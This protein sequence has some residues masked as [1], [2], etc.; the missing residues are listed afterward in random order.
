MYIISKFDFCLPIRIRQKIQKELKYVRF[1]RNIS[2]KASITLLITVTVLIYSVITLSGYTQMTNDIGANLEENQQMIQTLNQETEATIENNLEQMTVQMNQSFVLFLNK[3]KQILQ[4]MEQ[5][6]KLDVLSE[7]E[8]IPQGQT[9]GTPYEI[10]P[11]ENREDVNRSL[12]PYF[13]N[14]VNGIEEIQ[15]AYVG[16]PDQ[17]MYI[18]PLGDF[19]FKEYDP[20]D[21]P[22]YQNAVQE[23]D[24]Y[25]WTDPYIDAI[26]EK[27]VMTLAK[28]VSRNDE[29][30][31]VTAMDF[32]LDTLSETVTD[33][34]IAD[35]GYAMLLDRNGVLLAHPHAEDR[36]GENVKTSFPFLEPVFQGE[37]GIL[38]Y[39]SEG[40]ERIGYY[41]TNEETGWKLV[42]T[43]PKNEMFNVNQ[44]I[45]NMDNQNESILTG[46]NERKT[47]MTFWFVGLGLLLVVSGF[48]V[49]HFYSRSVSRFISRINQAMVQLA[50]GDLTQHVPTDDR[51]QN[52]F[53]Q[54]SSNFNQMAEELRSL[55]QA[56]VDVS[57]RVDEA[58]SGMVAVSN[59]TQAGAE[60]MNHSINDTLHIIEQQTQEMQEMND[61]VHQFSQYVQEVGEASQDIE[62]SVEETNRVNQ[63][64]ASSIS[65]LEKSAENNL[66][67]SDVLSEHMLELNEQVK[68]VEEFTSTIQDIA[69]QTGLLALNA[70]IEAARV[71]EEGNG[72]AVVADEI[73]KLSD[74]SSTSA[75]EIEETIQKTNEKVRLTVNS[76]DESKRSAYEHRDVFQNSKHAFESV[77]ENI[78]KIGT[79]MNRVSEIVGELVHKNQELKQTMAN[80]KTLNDESA[81]LAEDIWG[82]VDEQAEAIQEAAA[83]TEQLSVASEQLHREIPK[84]KIK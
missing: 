57:T 54:L 35:Q 68:T 74:Q 10:L 36:L 48:I 37:E 9:N 39:T 19:D 16:T 75:Q 25:I 66:E 41:V 76:L 21:R 60:R 78:K 2:I 63:E 56:N 47:Q 50:G 6:E 42:T 71:G 55:V 18:G 24:R 32:S 77:E 4:T 7:H 15:Y 62:R 8:Q 40:T 22:W 79:H 72:F 11:P 59:R 46:L 33:I 34:K 81:R 38:N 45:E 44:V 84:F 64:A 49:A 52:E 14:M 43:V 5:G 17:A 83:S 61:T 51:N 69:G 27:P 30:T 3:M 80:N 1:L 29:L 73:R 53:T 31:G 13:A 82:I 23:P 12:I 58:S 20:T 70:A 28:A 67:A 65:A 26:T